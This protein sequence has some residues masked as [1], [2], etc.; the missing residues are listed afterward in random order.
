MSF[1]SKKTFDSVK[2]SSSESGLN[3]TLTAFDLILLGLGGIIGTGVFV[4]TGLVAA[5][6]AGPA[7]MLSY[8]IA[9]GVCIFVALA[10]T[11][12]ASMLPTSGSVYTYTYVAF[13]Q[14]FAWMMGGVLILEFLLSSAAVAAGWSAYVQSIL[15]QANIH[16]PSYLSDVSAYGGFINLP[17]IFITITVGLILY[18]G[19]KDSKRF[20]AALVLIK[21]AAIVAFMIAAIPHF[22]IKNWEP[23]MPFGFDD[24]LIGSSILFFAFTGFGA[25]ATSAEECK[26]PKKDLMIGIIGSLVLS[27]IIYVIM[28]GLATGI[29]PYTELDNASPLANALTI[30]GSKLGSVIVSTGGVCGMT[31]VIMMNVYALSRV[32]Y[33]ISRDG[34]LPKFFAKLHP[35]YDSPHVTILTFTGIIALLSGFLPYDIL[36]KLS[37]MG[38]LLD[39]IVITMIVVVFRVRYPNAPRSFS[40][41][42]LYFV[43][44][45]AFLASAYLL[46]KQVVDKDGL[47][48]TGKL[49]GFWFA[50]A[51]VLY[52]ARKPWIKT[53][54]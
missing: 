27:T 26:N 23:F 37:S 28:G 39:Y 50:A 8:A 49:V 6:H 43:A 53:E 21:M 42:A 10:Y 25:L 31:T 41:P 4:F 2:E 17:A 3:K 29:V 35:K 46:S 30:N 45:V 20:N 34:L 54:A 32:F 5:Q 11:E 24:V 18:H 9:G 40:C 51:F 19:T 52:L 44:P 22:D 15:E 7:V 12:I 16:L 1:F 13:G 14:M 48:L 36:G 38:A 47:L 33:V